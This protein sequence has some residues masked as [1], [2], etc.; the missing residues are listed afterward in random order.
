[1]AKNRIWWSRRSSIIAACL[2][3]ANLMERGGTG[4]QTMIE[5]YSGNADHL[6]P[7][8]L[9]YPGFLDLRLFDR[10]YEDNAAY[11]TREELSDAK[12]VLELLRKE[13]PKHVKE[14]QAVTN[15]KSRSQFLTEIINS[16]IAE[17]L[18]LRWKREV[19]K[20]TYKVEE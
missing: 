8:V 14:L 6:Q 12:K 1:M 10:F 5:S 11:I 7:V 15:Y 18:I 16:L 13:G 9:I 2:D 19:T 3:M 4:F 17:G 20:G